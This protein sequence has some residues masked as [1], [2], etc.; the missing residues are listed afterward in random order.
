MSD[1]CVLCGRD[2]TPTETRT[3][4]RCLGRARRDLHT[5]A[6]LFA[7][8]P[9]L[10]G[11]PDGAT[12]GAVMGGRSD[13]AGLPG[14]DVLAMLGPGAESGQG[15]PSDPPA[16]AFEL[17]TWV[18]VWA[19]AR[20]EPL[21]RSTS[22]ACS[23]GWLS[24]RTGWAAAHLDAFDEY[25]ADLARIVG[26]LEVVTGMHDRPEVGPPCPYCRD[27]DLLRHFTDQGLADE[28]VCARCERAFGY[29][30]YV[31]AL[32]AQ[33]ESARMESQRVAG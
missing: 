18:E 33:L 32:R 6:R 17:G 25:A 21:P 3:C 12:L 19:E 10:L 26:R 28:W 15:L 31:L 20:S 16:V 22:V 7:L 27:A 1:R 23:V 9:A 30:Q 11:R 8:L 4:L 29:A 14:G 5:V 2:L 24:A 13:A